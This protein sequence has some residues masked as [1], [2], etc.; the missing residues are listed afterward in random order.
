MDKEASWDGTN[1][2]GTIVNNGV[3]Y[4][5][6]LVID[7]N[8]YKTVAQTQITVMHAGYDVIGNVRIEP[9]P[10]R[11]K[12]NNVLTIKYKINNNTKVS[13]KVYNIAGELVKTLHD[14]NNAG[15]IK[16]E[17]KDSGNKIASGIYIMVIYAKTDKGQT[18]TVIL[19]FAII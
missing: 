16:W 8:G 15:E 19:K 7:E 17:I 5:Q 12:T 3:Y 1:E 14:Y 10:F 9:N 13:I 4:I 18:E 11:Y 2:N 6:L